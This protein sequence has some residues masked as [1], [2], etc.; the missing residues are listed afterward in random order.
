M[1]RHVVGNQVYLGSFFDNSETEIV[2][3]SLPLL[4]EEV[5]FRLPL[6][7]LDL[8]PDGQK[9][10][11]SQRNAGRGADI[12]ELDLAS[13]SARL[14]GRIP[15]RLLRYPMPTTNGLAFVSVRLTSDLY[16]RRPG[17]LLTNLT[18]NGHIL[19]ANRCGRDLI[20]SRE[21]EPE[22]TVI[23]RLDGAGRHLERLSEG[24]RDWSPAC[25]PDGKVWFYR[26]HKPY[27]AIRRCDRGGCRDIFH[28]FA[29]GL[30]ASPDGKRLAFVTVD[31]R[32]SIVQWIRADGGET[33]DVGET[34][35]ACPVG[36]ASADT[37][38]VSR[39]R[40]RAIVWTEVDAE[41]GRE[42]G[43][44]AGGTRDCAD[45]RPD[46]ASPVNPDLRVIYDQTSQVRLVAHEHLSQ[47]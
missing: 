18:K 43:R 46:P 39:R 31:K 14:I 19:D 35:T 37:I 3:I 40:D 17:G 4:K 25:T 7:A 36:W 28:G 6:L 33:H 41:T 5:R 24:P 13:G 12:A 34:E 30:A 23:E 26:P 15:D 32:G 27:P 10:V 29:I 11:F 2:G 9:L 42:T 47:R 22:R 44:T 20:V 38:W 8:R 16:L 45:A 21:I 1:F